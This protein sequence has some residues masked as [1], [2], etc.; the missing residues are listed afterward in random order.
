MFAVKMIRVFTLVPGSTTTVPVPNAVLLCT[1]TSPR[2]SSTCPERPLLSPDK[3]SPPASI[4]RKPLVP[5]SDKLT[6]SD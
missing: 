4:F 5:A 1:V 2:L 6:V 3:I